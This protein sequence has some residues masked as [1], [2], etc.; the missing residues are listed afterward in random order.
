MRE[1][2][3]F[4]KDAF[5]KFG[6]LPIDGYHWIRIKDP[7]PKPIKHL[8]RAPKKY[9]FKLPK[10]EY[11]KPTKKDDSPLVEGR[12]LLKKNVLSLRKTLSIFLQ[13]NW[14]TIKDRTNERIEQRM[15]D[16]AEGLRRE[17]RRLVFAG[18]PKETYILGW[19]DTWLWD[20]FSAVPSSRVLAERVGRSRISRMEAL[21]KEVQVRNFGMPVSF[22]LTF[23]Y[24]D[25][26]V[27]S[28]KIP[29]VYR[30]SIR[31]DKKE[32]EPGP[33]YLTGNKIP[34]R[35]SRR[36]A[37]KIMRNAAAQLLVHELDESFFVGEDRYF[38][39]HDQSRLIPEP[40]EPLKP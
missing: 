39:P 34:Y 10:P 17:S 12:E 26:M 18:N 15:L 29:V 24:T 1:K 14:E 36:E 6:S 9:L 31:F 27:F 38:D 20:H 25:Y 2:T 23:H 7:D 28:V 19:F 40:I 13:D 37:L 35:S 22:E 3:F 5:M 4:G 32:G 21:L 33:L 16:E 8:K 11:G 30:E